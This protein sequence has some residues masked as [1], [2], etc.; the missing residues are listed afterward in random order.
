MAQSVL[1]LV[2]YASNN[3]D[4]K[5]SLRG[6]ISVHCSLFW[7]VILFAMETLYLLSLYWKPQEGSEYGLSH[8][9]NS[10]QWFVENI[11][12][13]KPALRLKCAF[14]AVVL[15]WRMLLPKR[16]GRWQNTYN[17]YFV[18]NQNEVKI[19]VTLQPK[20]WWVQTTSKAEQ[21]FI[22]SVLLP[23]MLTD[24]SIMG[25]W[26]RSLIY[27]PIC[28]DSCPDV[29]WPLANHSH[30]FTNTQNHATV[31]H[32]KARWKISCHLIKIALIVSSPHV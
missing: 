30:N 6:I 26:T 19:P 15:Q 10:N 14:A 11:F 8:Q 3:K 28:P 18:I 1:F 13:I 29:L 32:Y 5:S 20:W 31:D 4:L 9:K 17:T 21:P 12:K 22:S 24:W 7:D 23:F 25:T 27:H 2:L 16:N